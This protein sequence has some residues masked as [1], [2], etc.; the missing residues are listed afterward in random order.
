MFSLK[1][2]IDTMKNKM[3]FSQREDL[4]LIADTK[5]TLMKPGQ[6]LYLRYISKIE[7]VMKIIFKKTE[8][9]ISPMPWTDNEEE[10]NYVNNVIK[11]I[12]LYTVRSPNDYR[13]RLLVD[14]DQSPGADQEYYDDF[15][16]VIDAK[17]LKEQGY[18]DNEIGEN[19]KIFT[20]QLSLF[21]IVLR[22]S[23]WYPSLEDSKQEAEDIE[24]F[25]EKSDGNEEVTDSSII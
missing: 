6:D 22:K 15:N 9:D 24:T 18:Y 20:P 3:L 10:Y 25:P 1:R 21:F 23:G 11:A 17:I 19:T 2:M 16:P 5:I 8:G 12:L 4:Q 7:K 14:N 13:K